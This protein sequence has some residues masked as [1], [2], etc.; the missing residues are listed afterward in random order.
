LIPL[1]VQQRSWNPLILVVYQ[2][3]SKEINACER[4]ECQVEL[5]SV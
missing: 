4:Y 1:D 5:C 2:M 3:L